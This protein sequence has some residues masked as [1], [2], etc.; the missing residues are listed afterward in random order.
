MRDS[1]DVCRIDQV[2]REPAIEVLLS[3]ETVDEFSELVGVAGSDRRRQIFQPYHFVVAR[4]VA[5]IQ[6]VPAA[7]FGSDGEPFF[8][9]ATCIT[10]ALR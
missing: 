4:V 8:R 2:R 1:I 7:K 10:P 5:F 9:L 6:F 3:H